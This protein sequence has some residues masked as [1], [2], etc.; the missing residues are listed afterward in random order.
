MYSDDPDA[1][2]GR[3]PSSL[4]A[5]I[6]LVATTGVPYRTSSVSCPETEPSPS[7]SLPIRRGDTIFGVLHAVFY[8]GH[9]YAEHEQHYLEAA[10]DIL[11]ITWSLVQV[12][13]DV[14][15]ERAFNSSLLASAQAYIA[16]L[17]MDGT[18]N[19]MN[20]SALDALGWADASEKTLQD[21]VPF[22]GGVDE[23]D[24]S[25]VIGE[26]ALSGM[27]RPVT[28]AILRRHREKQGSTP[29]R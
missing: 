22:L 18:I 14:R 5:Q 19:Q 28:H 9:P 7:L 13:T 24:V 15:T 10:C 2:E 17:D 26:I 29:R 23:A 27:P 21:I 11:A 3:I 12:L 8:P 20:P 1:R 16:V 25:R 6:R 4:E